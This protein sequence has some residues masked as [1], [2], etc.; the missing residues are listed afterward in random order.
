MPGEGGAAQGAG[1]ALADVLAQQAQVG[2]P[3]AA[4]QPGA[5]R[6]EVPVGAGTGGGH[7]SRG[8]LAPDAGDR[9]RGRVGIGGGGLQGHGLSMDMSPRP[10]EGGASHSSGKQKKKTLKAVGASA[11]QAAARARAEYT[12]AIDAIQPTVTDPRDP[13]F[14]DAQRK[15]AKQIR[16]EWIFANKLLDSGALW[17]SNNPAH[18]S[19][20]GKGLL[21][22]ANAVTA[23][24]WL[25]GHG[26]NYAFRPALSAAGVKTTSQKYRQRPP[27]F[28]LMVQMA[29]GH[30]GV[31]S[32][33]T[34]MDSRDAGFNQ[35]PEEL[36]FG[37]ERSA[38]R[39]R[40]WVYLVAAMHAS[41]ALG[42]VLTTPPA[43]IVLLCMSSGSM[44]GTHM[45]A[46]NS[47]SVAE[48]A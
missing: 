10:V 29:F 30:A 35:T 47:G 43:N 23:K 18:S 12:R 46:H 9:A 33:K 26:P 40:W 15:C 3:A 8:A 20:Q 28:E 1:G 34:V 14:Q 39:T 48:C 6:G 24:E 5:A 44:P 7:S 37:S 21:A 32:I 11:Q 25:V 13:G 38:G 36:M 31:D 16:D 19:R 22:A 4:P 41:D 45:P 17:D 27:W 42:K 2:Q